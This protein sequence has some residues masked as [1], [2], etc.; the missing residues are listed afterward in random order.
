M[1]GASWVRGGRE[2]VQSGP[3]GPL[4]KPD[5]EIQ[6]LSRTSKVLLPVTNFQ[7]LE[8][9]FERHAPSVVSRAAANTE[10]G[11]ALGRG[12]W[13]GEMYYGRTCTS[14]GGGSINSICTELA[15]NNM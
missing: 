12:L 6:I 5:R 2:I 3:Q 7:R 10:C 11:L 9:K 4:E 13:C 8:L 15:S 1:V 14:R